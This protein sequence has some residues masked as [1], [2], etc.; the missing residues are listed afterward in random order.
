MISKM[1]NFAHFF[2]NWDLRPS[3]QWPELANRSFHLIRF[4]LNL[5][6]YFQ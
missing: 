1:E 4:S 6:G 2:N 3:Q 5:V